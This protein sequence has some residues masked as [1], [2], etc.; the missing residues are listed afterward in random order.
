MGGRVV[1]WV[2]VRVDERV[3]ERVDERVDERQD[4][5]DERVDERVYESVGDMCETRGAVRVTTEDTTKYPSHHMQ[6]VA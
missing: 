5:V 6:K 3:Y 1:G 2:G 4:R